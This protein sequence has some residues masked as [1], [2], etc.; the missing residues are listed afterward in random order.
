MYKLNSKQWIS[1]CIYILVFRVL[2]A[3]HLHHNALVPQTFFLYLE[4]CCLTHVNTISLVTPSLDTPVTN[5][6]V[7]IPF[8]VFSI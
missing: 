6:V 7:S 8:P 3:E 1:Y 4:L 2:V 5:E